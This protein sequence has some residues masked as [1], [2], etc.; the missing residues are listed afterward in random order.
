MRIRK[1]Y[2]G[3][4]YFDPQVLQRVYQECMDKHSRNTVIHISPAEF[5]ALALRRKNYEQGEKLGG[6]RELL[7]KGVKFNEIPYLT[8][9]TRP[10]GDLTVISHE[11][12]HRSV[13]LES[14]GVHKIPVVLRSKPCD[15]GHSFRWHATEIRPNKL[16]SQTPGHA[17]IKMP[18]LDIIR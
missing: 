7:D 13:M 12:R 14:L 10:D 17:V 11:G 1:H 15:D 18:L 4:D 16:Y 3:D 8:V 9:T 5:L 6:V 2:D